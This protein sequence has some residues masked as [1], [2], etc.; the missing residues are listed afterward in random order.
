MKIKILRGAAISGTVTLS[1]GV[2]GGGNDVL[3]KTLTGMN[4]RLNPE[5]WCLSSYT[6][7]TE[8]FIEHLV[9]ARCQ[10]T[11]NQRGSTCIIKELRHLSHTSS[12]I[13]VLPPAAWVTL[14]KPLSSLS[15]HFS[16]CEMGT[17]SWAELWATLPKMSA[18]EIGA[19]RAFEKT[20]PEMQKGNHGR[21]HWKRKEV[22]KKYFMMSKE[23]GLGVR[24]EK[25]TLDFSMGRHLTICR[26]SPNCSSSPSRMAFSHLIFPQFFTLSIPC[27]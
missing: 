10:D 4:N 7:L 20:L 14:D 19:C 25:P 23:T 24:L 21:H 27:L 15:L 26:K 2:G 1:L 22:S 13:M 3:T 9:H 12:S 11:L 17:D 5:E 18:K 8:L 6:A 16:F